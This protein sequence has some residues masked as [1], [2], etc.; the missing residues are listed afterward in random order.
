MSDHPLSSTPLLD[1]SPYVTSESELTHS[2]VQGLSLRII[3]LYAIV[4][5]F[6][7]SHC[8]MYAILYTRYYLTS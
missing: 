8:A 1:I 5:L 3:P 4:V 2:L 7:L 6:T